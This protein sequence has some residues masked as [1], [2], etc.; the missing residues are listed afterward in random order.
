MA[1]QIV[2]PLDSYTIILNMNVFIFALVLITIYRR[3]S[4]YMM[5]LYNFDRAPQKE[6]KF[7]YTIIDIISVVLAIISLILIISVDSN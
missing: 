2:I 4:G 7:A 1:P 3:Y 5:K 6:K